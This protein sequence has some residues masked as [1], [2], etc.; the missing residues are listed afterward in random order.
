MTTETTQK[1]TG[2]LDIE[3]RKIRLRSQVEAMKAKREKRTIS[4]YE[5]ELKAAIDLLK[6]YGL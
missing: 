2:V 1:P 4:Q 3:L 6:L 5:K